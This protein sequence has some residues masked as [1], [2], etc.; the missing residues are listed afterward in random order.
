MKIKTFDSGIFDSN[1]YLVWNESSRV[2]II[3]DCG[4][5]KDEIQ[6]FVQ[7]NG[8]KVTQIILTHGHYDHA[9][10][11]RDHLEAFEGAELLAHKKELALLSDPIANLTA[12][13]GEGEAYSTP[14]RA[15]CNGD[16]VVIP[17]DMPGN[18]IEFK[19]IDAPGHTEGS[20]LLYCEKEKIM[21]AGDVIF[22]N[23]RG[24]TDLPYGDE[25]VM[26]STLA[27]IR[28][29]DGDIVF[30]P[31]HG[32]PDSLLRWNKAQR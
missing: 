25:S 28:K 10:F 8:I 21:F 2:G 15:L 26:Q 20:F 30:Y 24:R 18:D 6:A 29:M 4:N 14:N 13:F 1:E 32:A 31:G 16:S 9:E 12:Y 22:K 7:D 11:T 27:E 3:I 23:G 19:V 17:G 5:Y